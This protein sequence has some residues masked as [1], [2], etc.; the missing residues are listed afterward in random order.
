[1][2]AWSVFKF[3]GICNLLLIGSVGSVEQGIKFDRAL[4]DTLFGGST[5]VPQNLVIILF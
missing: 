2:R 5:V 3:T 4:S 1:M